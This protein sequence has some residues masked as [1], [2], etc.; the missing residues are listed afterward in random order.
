MAP[1][2]FFKAVLITGLIAGF[3]D[4]AAASIQYYINT[5]NNP[6]RI[7]RYIASAGLGKEVMTK[8]LYAMAAWGLLFHFMIAW[9]FTFLF[10]ICFRQIRMLLKNKIAAGIVYGIFVW[11]VMNLLVVP[12]AFGVDFGVQYQKYFDNIKNSMIAM[13]ILI[14]A[15]GLPVSLL[16][17]RYYSKKIS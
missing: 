16:A 3:L 2:K 5:G 15:I 6:A 10:F 7:F 17:D 4:A 11:C 8:D 13:S 9:S 1:N 12:L 14:I